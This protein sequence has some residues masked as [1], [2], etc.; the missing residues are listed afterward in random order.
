M[1]LGRRLR[2]LE[3]EHAGEDAQFFIFRTFY[4]EKDG[5][6]SDANAIA[7]A[8]INWG[9]FEGASVSK[10]RDESMEGFD[11][12]V[13]AY[14]ELTWQEAQNAKGLRIWGK[15]IKLESKCA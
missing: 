2:K 8:S 12:R 15:S 14:A 10:S 3:T 5:S 13:R 4:E 11:T 9:K 6:I 1:N 7:R